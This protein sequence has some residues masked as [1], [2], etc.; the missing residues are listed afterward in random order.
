[1]T[2]TTLSTVAEAEHGHAELGGDEHDQD[3][4][5]VLHIAGGSD[6][7]MRV[8]EQCKTLTG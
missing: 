8:G 2:Y 6:Q 3:T 7:L 4:D 1:M 5:D